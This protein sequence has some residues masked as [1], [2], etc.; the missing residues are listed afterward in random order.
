MKFQSLGML[1][2][3]M[4]NI[5]SSNSNESIY[6]VYEIVMLVCWKYMWKVLLSVPSNQEN[7]QMRHRK[8][9]WANEN[10]HKVL[11]YYI[12]W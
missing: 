8:M 9:T 7:M 1:E 11:I 10:L 5:S 2:I 6:S 12:E 3:Q 4:I